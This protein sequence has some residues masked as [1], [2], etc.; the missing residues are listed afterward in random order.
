MAETAVQR[1][2]CDRVERLRQSTLASA[3]ASKGVRPVSVTSME[4][5]HQEN[6]KKSACNNYNQQIR[7]HKRSQEL[8]LRSLRNLRGDMR[9]LL[10]LDGLA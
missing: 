2:D 9:D 6:R 3:D 5:L 10:L 8:D 4:S 7:N 1:S